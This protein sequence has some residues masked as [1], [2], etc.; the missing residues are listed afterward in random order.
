MSIPCVTEATCT[1]DPL[2]FNQSNKLN[3]CL[4]YPYYK[5]H[6]LFIDI[7]I[8]EWD[9]FN[10][11][12]FKSGIAGIKLLGEL[13][14]N[15][16]GIVFEVIKDGKHDYYMAC[17]VEAGDAS[18]GVPGLTGLLQCLI[19]ELNKGDKTINW[20]SPAVIQAGKIC[21][22]KSAYFTDTTLSS[23]HSAQERINVVLQNCNLSLEGSGEPIPLLF[24]K[25]N[26]SRSINHTA[27]NTLTN[28]F[29]Y[30]W[31]IS[32]AN[33]KYVFLGAKALEPDMDTGKEIIGYP[34]TCETFGS[35][36]AS[37]IFKE[38]NNEILSNP[39]LN[40][41]YNNLLNVE[42]TG[43]TNQIETIIKGRY[44]NEQIFLQFIRGGFLNST[45]NSIESL[46][47]VEWDNLTSLQKE[48]CYN[49]YAVLNKL[50]LTLASNIES[51]ISLYMQRPI[52]KDKIKKNF[53][54]KNFFSEIAESNV[55][56]FWIRCYKN[57][58]YLKNPKPFYYS[59]PLKKNEVTIDKIK[60]T[61]NFEIKSIKYTYDLDII[62]NMLGLTVSSALGEKD[63]DPMINIE[64]LNKNSLVLPSPASPTS[65]PIQSRP[66]S[67]SGSTIAI[68]VIISVISLLLLIYAFRRFR[69]H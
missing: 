57:Q 55:S 20:H 33:I 38:F 17:E 18:G 66:S 21:L 50:S 16:T 11:Y 42:S 13:G 8:S 39:I 31:K 59:F 48:D 69:H 44:Q 46:S 28:F 56:N 15:H 24:L 10:F 35:I 19:P 45:T 22:P 6:E 9:Q 54:F 37:F 47:A 61:K 58:N 64:L 14:V 26:S 1:G 63:F 27:K 62:T 3:Q 30:I 4:F 2:C 29:N 43:T 60:N 25:K 32:N 65:S 53:L 52:D 49:F 12:L 36:A 51:L 34:Y 40:N 7:V 41:I 5:Y 23:Y 67:I 68:I